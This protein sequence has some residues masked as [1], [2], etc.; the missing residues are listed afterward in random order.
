MIERCALRQTKEG[1]GTDAWVWH[2]DE[3]P[4]CGIEKRSMHTLCAT[5]AVRHALATTPTE[6]DDSS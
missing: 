3:C 5:C 4:E 6:S 2:L 1:E